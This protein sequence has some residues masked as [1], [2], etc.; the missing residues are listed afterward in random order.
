MGLHLSLLSS[1]HFIWSQPGYWPQETASHPT[2]YPFPQAF[3]LKSHLWRPVWFPC[4]RSGILSRKPNPGLSHEAEVS[5]AVLETEGEGLGKKLLKPWEPGLLQSLMHNP[6]TSLA[7]SPSCSQ[8]VYGGGGRGT[9]GTEAP[10]LPPW[11]PGKSIFTVVSCEPNFFHLSLFVLRK[12]GTLPL[13]NLTKNPQPQEWINYYY[14]TKWTLLVNFVC[15]IFAFSA[16]LSHV[17]LIWE[18]EP[19]LVPLDWENVFIRLPMAKSIM[20]F[21]D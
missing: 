19:E 6:A 17:R 12:S 1:S 11:L 5:T 9:K 8:S 7:P 4:T 15:C 10:F 13:I 3:L 20:S 18:R 21:L 14:S 16:C 2:S